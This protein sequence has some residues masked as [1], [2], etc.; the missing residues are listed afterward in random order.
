MRVQILSAAITKQSV[1]PRLHIRT[2]R[3]IPQELAKFALKSE[4]LLDEVRVGGR[5]N[6]I[7]GRGLTRRARESLGLPP[8]QGERWGGEGGR[9]GWGRRGSSDP[10]HSPPPS[11]SGEA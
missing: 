7:I 10:H 11:S 6:L 8:G 9:E 1:F 5:I 3:S 2:L 4:V